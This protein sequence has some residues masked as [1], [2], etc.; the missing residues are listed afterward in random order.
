MNEIPHIVSTFHIL[1]LA[2]EATAH[3][4]SS[5]LSPFGYHLHVT[6]DFHESIQHIMAEQPSML[7]ISGQMQDDEGLALLQY[8]KTHQDYDELP[9]MFFSDGSEE[10]ELRA[11]QIGAEDVC[12]LTT[13]EVAVRARLR[14]L[15]RIAGYRRRISNEKRRL[16]ITVEQR[17]KELLEITVATVA[18]LEKASELS[19]EETGEHM[20]RVAA[21]SA[22]LAEEMGLDR[23]MVEK[24]RLYAPLHDVGKVGV[25]HE[26]LK[27]AGVL[28]NEEFDEMKQHTVFGYD[29]LTAAKADDVA[30]NIALY[31]HERYDGSGYPYNL[32][33]DEIPLEARIV[34][35]ADVFDALTTKRRY[36]EALPPKDALQITCVELGERFDP[37]VRQALINR[38]DQ[39]VAIMQQTTGEE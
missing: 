10:Q 19:D 21:Y 25:R 23:A 9:V 36:K 3:Y 14:V 20:M 38:F 5:I 15:L 17:T 2:E 7:I 24:I 29:L 4:L 26:V 33:K 1:T 18:A 12:S 31:H 28:T 37:T 34:A 8:L 22:C 16:E 30:R 35:V 32:K 27:K 13:S 6:K 39:F 11:Y